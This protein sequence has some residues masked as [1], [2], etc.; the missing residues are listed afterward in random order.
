MEIRVDKELIE[1]IIK[2]IEQ[3]EDKIEWEFGGCRELE[4]II[5]VGDMPE[6][7]YQLKELINKE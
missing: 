7:Y 5:E 1:N 4:E 3:V 6:I 2:Y